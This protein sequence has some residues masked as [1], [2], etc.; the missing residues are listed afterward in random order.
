MVH[1]PL[2]IVIIVTMIKINI[3]HVVHK[4]KSKKTEKKLQV[5]N[6]KN[7][8]AHIIKNIGIKH[9]LSLFQ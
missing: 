5:T 1:G 2:S 7:Y 9:S 8:T 6:N 4:K 3:L